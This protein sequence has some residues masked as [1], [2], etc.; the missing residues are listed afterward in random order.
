MTVIG[1]VEQFG[2]ETELQGDRKAALLEETPPAF[3]QGLQ[4]RL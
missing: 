2:V 4:E 1:R 3:V